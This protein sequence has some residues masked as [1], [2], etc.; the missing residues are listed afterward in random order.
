MSIKV[1]QS[2]E[3]ETTLL[4]VKGKSPVFTLGSGGFQLTPPSAKD[5]KPVSQPADEV[6]AYVNEIANGRKIIV[7]WDPPAGSPPSIATPR[8]QPTTVATSPGD[9]LVTPDSDNILER[10]I[11]SAFQSQLP[12]GRVSQPKVSFITSM[13]GMD[14]FIATY[15]SIQSGKQR[16]D[17]VIIRVRKRIHCHLIEM[18]RTNDPKE[19]HSID[20]FRAPLAKAQQLFDRFGIDLVF[21]D[22][23]IEPERLTQFFETRTEAQLKAMLPEA[24]KASQKPTH[25]WIN[26]VSKIKGR[27]GHEEDGLGGMSQVH[28]EI[29]KNLDAKKAYESWRE[30]WQ[31]SKDHMTSDQWLRRFK[32]EDRKLAKEIAMEVITPESISTLNLNTLLV[33]EIGHALGL[34]P[35]DGKAGGVDQSSWHDSDNSGHCVTKT[36]VMFWKAGSSTLGFEAQLGSHEPFNHVP[37]FMGTK[38]DE[39]ACN[40]FLRACDLSN[41]SNLGH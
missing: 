2:Q 35:T 29:Q 15:R 18:K 36:C 21:R 30:S 5:K 32:T 27:R 9:W 31:Q 17:H 33:H 6:V 34:V 13:C 16:L 39:V 41:L 4:P 26:V 14:A 10:K 11:D 38:N 1:Y 28:V 8:T 40:L 3:A 19:T 12:S 20:D 37:E 24:Q 23:K 25:L 22:D 7:V